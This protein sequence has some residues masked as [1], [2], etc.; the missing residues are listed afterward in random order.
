MTK[1]TL[2][3]D[4]LCSMECLNCFPEANSH[5]NCPLPEHICQFAF[6]TECGCSSED[7]LP[8]RFD[9]TLTNATGIKVHGARHAFPPVCFKF[10]KK[11]RN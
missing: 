6:P 2:V 8:T 11:M 7:I 9:F 5:F 3:T 10:K 1:D 4:I